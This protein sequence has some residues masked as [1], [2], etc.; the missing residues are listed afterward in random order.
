MIIAIVGGVGSGK[1]LLATKKVIESPFHSY[2]NYEVKSKNCTRLKKSHIILDNIEMVG[3]NNDKEKH[4]YAVNWP[5]WNDALVKHKDF[6][7]V[8]DEVHNLFHSR[9]SNSTWS[10]LGTIWISQIRKILGESEKTHL[11]LIT[12]KVHRMD[13]AFRDLLNKII[14]CK[15]F[16]LPYTIRMI[17]KD[18]H[19]I[20]VLKEVPIVKCVQ[21]HFLGDYALENYLSWSSQNRKTYQ[22]LT[23]FIGNA[24]F[25]KYNTFQFF[26]ESAYL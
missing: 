23:H 11:Y 16:K 9:K 5:Y 8:I 26:G 21:Y 4:N 13:V 17:V 2:V 24:Y 14:A 15:T 19:G 22:Y 6:N 1:S 7:L 12:Q 3:K 20:D 18:R 10:V 25:D